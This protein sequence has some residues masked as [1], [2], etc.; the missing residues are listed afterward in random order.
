MRG[1]DTLMPHRIRRIT[2]LATVMLLVCAVQVEADAKVDPMATEQL[3]KMSEY[4]ARQKQ[5][6]FQA[7]ATTQ[8][9]MPT[10]EK[11]DLDIENH[12]TVQRPNMLRSERTGA[13]N[14]ALYYDGRQVTFY[15]KRDNAFATTAAP[16]TLDE[17]IDFARDRLGLEAPGADLLYGNPYSVLMEDVIGAT[18]VGQVVVR[19]VLC[20][21]LVFRG[22]ETDWQIWI[23][24]GSNPLPIKWVVVS[25]KM[26]G[27][28][29]FRVELSRWNLKPNLDASAFRFTPPKGAKRVAFADVPFAVGAGR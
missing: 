3:R 29:E 9:I 17:M 2:G 21:H 18:Y 12:V 28:P 5:F 22:R 1:G 23:S 13:A 20:H 25:K 7:D 19:D 27:S 16:G 26:Q 11:V 10:G 6:A 14:A 15:G 24:E 8:V 4:L